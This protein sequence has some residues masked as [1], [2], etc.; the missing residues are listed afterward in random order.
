MGCTLLVTGKHVLQNLRVIQGVIN[1]DGLSSRIAEDHLYALSLEGCDEG[2][3]AS[4][5]L[6]LFFGMATVL[7]H[8]L[9]RHD[10]FLSTHYPKYAPSSA[11]ETSFA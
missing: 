10:G 2:L 11:L 3:S 8:T 1:L 4:H 9:L 7:G 6:S 5:H